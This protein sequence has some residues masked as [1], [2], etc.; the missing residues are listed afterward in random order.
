MTHPTI[1]AADAAYY[2]AKERNPQGSFDHMSAVARVIL[3]APPSE[4]EVEAANDAWFAELFAWR[5]P[6]ANRAGAMEKMLAALTAA[7]TKRLEEL[8]GK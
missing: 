1:E 2:A 7:Y 5:N 3:S 8:E 4:A 6:P